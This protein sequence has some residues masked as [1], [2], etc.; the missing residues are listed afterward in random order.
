MLF[1][2]LSLFFAILYTITVFPFCL[3][4]PMSLKIKYS[5]YGI[6]VILFIQEIT[7][8]ISYEIRG[9]EHLPKD[10]PYIVASEHQSPLETLILF[11]I[12]KDP[13]YIL[14]RELMYFP[15]FGI[16]FILLKMIFIDRS[17]RIQALKHILALTA[18]HVKAGRTVIIFPQGSRVV[19][20]TKISIKPGITAIY[21]KLSIPVVPI[22]VNTGLFWPANILAFKKTPGKA[23][24][25]ILPPI[26]PG[27]TKQEFT[28]ELETRMS[29]ASKS[30]MKEALECSSSK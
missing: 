6:K 29:I 3:I 12:F 20:G 5:V 24:I 10:S 8:G 19:P 7:N 30:L 9:Y 17:N 15:I 16:Y 1:Y 26:Y 11:T 23:I 28:N 21:N 14:K 18:S 4:L 22:A 13:A 25:Q 2:I 27:L